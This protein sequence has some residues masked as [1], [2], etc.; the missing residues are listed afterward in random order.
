MG[1]HCCAIYHCCQSSLDSQDDRSHWL[2]LSAQEVEELEL[3]LH[4]R[5]SALSNAIG[6]GHCGC[7]RES[8]GFRI[9]ATGF[10]AKGGRLRLV[11]AAAW[12]ACSVRNFLT[13]AATSLS[14]CFFRLV[15]DGAWRP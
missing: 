12:A 9:S 7:C 8:V 1:R 15:G 10:V 6:G 2:V 13:D 14:A 3:E 5:R 11:L 4:S